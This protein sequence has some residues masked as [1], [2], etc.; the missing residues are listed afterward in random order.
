MKMKQN[1]EI[2][3]NGKKKRKKPRNSYGNEL[4]FLTEAQNVG[5]VATLI[6]F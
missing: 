6:I 2:G 1:R 4:K 5:W 3:E